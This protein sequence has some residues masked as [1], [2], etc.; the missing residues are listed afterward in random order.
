[1]KTSKK[2]DA[3]IDIFEENDFQVHLIKEGKVLC[4]EVETWTAKGVN[5]IYFLR[6]FTVKSFEKCVKKFDIDTE[7]DLHRQGKLYR[8]HFRIADSLKDFEDHHAVLKAVLAKLKDAE[9]PGR[10]K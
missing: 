8:E 5:M 1:M 4:A 3:V 9:K 2:V 10:T 6:P 7:I